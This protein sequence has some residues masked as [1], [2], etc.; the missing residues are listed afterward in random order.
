MQSIQ[1]VNH[2]SSYQSLSDEQKSIVKL[3][4]LAYSYISLTSMGKA[5]ARIGIDEAG[6]PL[7]P[8]SLKV[9][10]KP[11][12]QAELLE[13]NAKQGQVRC[14]RWLAEV[15][16]REL[17]TEQQFETYLQ[18]LE[19][20]TPIGAYF[21]RYLNA[22]ECVRDARLAFYRGE[23]D[24]VTAI[25]DMAKNFVSQ[26]PL[27]AEL[28]LQWFVNPSDVDWFKRNRPATL[29][30]I[31]MF[32]GLHQ[33]LYLYADTEQEQFLNQQLLANNGGFQ[34]M[35]K[36]TVLELKLLKG[37]WDFVE[38][39]LLNEFDPE[40][41]AL[42]AALS[43][44]RGNPQ[45]AIEQ[46]E[47]ALATLR[48]QIG[49][50]SVYFEGMAGVFYPL[51][52]LKV[53]DRSQ[54]TKLNTLLNQAYKTNG[55]FASIFSK[56]Q[57]FQA[58]LQGDLQQRTHILR[59]DSDYV[60]SSGFKPSGVPNTLRVAPLMQQ[61]LSM[62]IK[63]WVKTENVNQVL[64]LSQK[65]YTHLRDNG[66]AWPAAELAKIFIEIEPRKA[67]Q[68]D[69]S[70]FNQDKQA[71]ADL[72]V[73][74]A[75]WE[76]ALDALSNLPKQDKKVLEAPVSERPTRLVWWLS[77]NDY[78]HTLSIEPREQKQQAKGKWTKGR[79]VALKRLHSERDQFDYLSEHDHKLCDQIKEFRDH[80]WYGSGTTFEF[81]VAMPLA[82]VGHPMLFWADT[83]EARVEVVQGQPELLV[84]KLPNSDKIKISMEPMP[85]FE[86]KMYVCKETP[87]RLKVVEFTPEHHKICS[88]VTAKGLEVPLSAQERVLQTL[89]SISGLL[90]V[91]SDIGGSSST[92]EQVSADA[93]PRI[94]LLPMGEGLR[95]ALLIRPF[96]TE[97]A[98]YQ[99]GRG[100]ES[101]FA[102][103]DGKPVQAKRDLA[104]EKQ[105]A[106]QLLDT[107]TELQ[108]AQ[109]DSSGEW[110][111]E[112]PEQC[113]ELLLQIQS[114]PEGAAILEW[115]EGVKFKLLGQSSG[116]GF[117]MQITRDN[118]W[119]ALQGE[120]KVGE[121][122]V[123]EIQQL[124]G[125]LNNQQ[126]RFL[127][128][129]DGQFI[130]LTDSF[131]RRLED[132]KAYADLSGKKVRLNPLAALTLEDW[133]DEAGF[134]ADEHW[135]AHLKRLQ[136]ARDY[137]PTVPS[138]F[139][140][141]LRDYQ[142]DG[143]NWLARLAEWG[144]G[145]CLADDM[146]LGKTVQGLALL[147]QRAPKG[148][149]LIVAPT[150][151][152][153][154]WENEA[155]RFAP[156]LKPQILG[157]GDRQAVMDKL[158]S[159]DLLICSYGLLQQESVA[160]L[161]ASIRFQTVILDEAQWIKNIAT[162]RS[163]GAM[164]LQA[165]FKVIM[166]GTPLENHLGELW[167]LFRFINPGLL[168]SLEQF[169]QRFAG[170]IERDR[171]AQARQQLKK[172]IQPFILRR[173]KTQV[174]QELPPRT[175]IPV[176]IELS[177]EETAFY[178][179]LRRES[180]AVLTS[181]DV[182]PGQKQLQILAAITKL[183]R[184][185]CNTNLVNPD[186]ALPSSKLAAFGDIVDELLANQH[187]ALVFSQFV[188]HLHLLEQYLQQ[189]GISYQYL[190]GSTPAKA[191]Q[192][193]VDAFQRG[194]GEL[195][196][197]SLKAGGVGLNLT[198]ADYVIHMDPWWNPAVED[199]ASDRAHRMGQQRPVTIYRMIAKNT[200]EEKIVALHG[201]KRDLADSLL[202]GA[203]IS[204]KM[205]ADD[206]LS[207][208]KG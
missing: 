71:L 135:Q 101:V 59:D 27:E 199:Q 173:T 160:E 132:L 121:E 84:K 145:A 177:S 76:L 94:H 44:L 108:Q 90:T 41:L 5:L 50:R 83:P 133:Q 20:P 21:H 36:Q 97:G 126:G 1:L 200:I 115:P 192:T 157:S 79:L 124:L 62:L 102:E 51:A 163:Q 153:M 7:K 64:P 180:L 98:Y 142:Q 195:F 38:Q 66:F 151:V 161:L 25:L 182:P 117:S 201:Q 54:Q 47:K 176:Y 190:D 186:L 18:A 78:S 72:F 189:R 150:S 148:P 134:S 68:W 17:V 119:F 164:N 10:L 187:K 89:T 56:L 120:L 204:G 167:N 86:Q 118:E 39:Q 45:V 146:G 184:S 136:D 85:S 130:A 23:Y 165:E 28:Y 46:F 166:T 16:A 33:Q 11:L 63:F 202:D 49:S 67:L 24:K 93:T 96:S 196:L 183:R 131:R 170:P 3:F 75:D 113:L 13:E 123:I 2:L 12:L 58:Y 14:S 191:R 159:Y 61:V 53:N 127:Q 193:R 208:M 77:Y 100:G 92:A 48:K 162:R 205:S 8:E 155:Q 181:N 188:D 197:I 43:F 154:N 179:A 105:C 40:L 111:L 55:Y 152:C 26:L 19:I 104:L 42:A 140:A 81:S 65:L 171:N 60:I 147:V 178:E 169:N 185:C 174:L 15:V 139:Q 112:E 109:R 168:G 203:D 137:Q 206:L 116:N 31:A 122:T 129:K 6:K 175:E 207:L 87:T 74:R 57:Q 144:V 4:A 95:V 198:A 194:E 106:E 35:I 22:E 80:S 32:V 128:L 73:S 91:H 156:T 30:Q 103:V 107:C 52:M 37:E 9:R 29:S 158:G 82:L 110:L 88:V 70:F 172:L 114:L 69:A 34:P 99:P 138:T 149:S 125:L 143:Y 141:E